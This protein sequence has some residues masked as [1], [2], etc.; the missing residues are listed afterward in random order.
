MDM[1][2]L[3]LT[4]IK[5][6]RKPEKSEYLWHNIFLFMHLKRKDRYY[7]QYHKIIY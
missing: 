5:E 7:F 4:T 6:K 1:N 2:R 3:M